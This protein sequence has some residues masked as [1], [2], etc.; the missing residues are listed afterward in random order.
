MKFANGDGRFNLAGANGNRL[1]RA[2]YV[3]IDVVD[4]PSTVSATI[5]YY[6]SGFDDEATIVAADLSVPNAILEPLPE[7]AITANDALGDIIIVL[8]PDALR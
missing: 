2:G 1:R 4:S 7:T 6:R 5:V 8:G 3:S